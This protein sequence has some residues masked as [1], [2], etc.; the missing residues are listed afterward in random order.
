M[1]KAYS[2][3][4]K[5]YWKCQCSCP[6]KTITY[7]PTDKLI[8]GHTRSCG[9]LTWHNLLGQAFGKL[10]VIEKTEQ[11]SNDGSVIWKCQCSC[12]NKTVIEVPSTKL[13]SGQI[14]HCGCEKDMSVGENTIALILTENHIPFQREKV[15]KELRY[16]NGSYPRFDF[17]VNN[18]YIIEFDG[19]QHF[20]SRENGWFNKEYVLAIQAKDSY[21]NNW[22]KENNIPIIRIPY[23]KLNTLS[24]TDLVPETSEFL[25]N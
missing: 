18:K 11:N 23:T 21:K 8:S 2:K 3:T 9:C 17:Y 7:V 20:N 19:E 1:E 4:Y 15:F 12:E 24:F 16:E 14:F 25:I 6:D 22:C 13:I 10:T 5:I